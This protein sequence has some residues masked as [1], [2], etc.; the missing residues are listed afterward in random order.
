MAV[1]DVRTPVVAGSLVRVK[2]GLRCSSGCSF[3]ERLV[4][5]V[6]ENGV[7]VGAG[8]LA[9]RPLEATEALYWANVDL[10]APDI[11]GVPSYR[12]TFSTTDLH[13]PHTPSDARFS[14]RTTGAPEHEVNITVV[15]KHTGAAVSDVEVRFGPYIQSTGAHGVVRINVPSGV[16]DV[17]IR[18]DGFGAPPSV[19]QVT[20]SMSVRIDGVVGPTMAEVAPRLTAFEGYPWG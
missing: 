12:V 16:Y 8:R 14:F 2:V 18:K 6:D 3:A 11:E 13:L 17:S 7:T 9:D 10:A 5:I 1:W 20:T 19:V 15:D 4:E